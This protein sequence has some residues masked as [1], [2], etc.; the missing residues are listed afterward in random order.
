MDSTFLNNTRR[1]GQWTRGAFHF[2]SAL[3]HDEERVVV[4]NN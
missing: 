2:C 4:K 3:E 1:G